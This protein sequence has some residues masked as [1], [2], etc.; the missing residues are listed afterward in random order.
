MPKAHLTHAFCVTAECEPG[1]KKTDWWCDRLTG[2]VLESRSSG[3]RTY[4]L[5]Y[6]DQGGRARQLKIGRF[7]DISHEAAVKAAKRLRSEVVLGGDP[8]AV[9]KEKRAVPTFSTLAAQA[10][11]FAKTYQ[12]RPE[13]FESILRRHVLDRW[14]KVRLDEITSRDVAKWLAEKSESGLAPATVEKVRVAL[15]RCLELGIR[16]ELPGAHNPL[17]GVPRRPFNNARNRFLSTEEAQ[18]LLRACERSSNHQLQHIVGLLLLTGARK[19]ELLHA[20]WKDVD[21][22]RGSWFIPDTKTKPRTVPLPQAAVEILKQLPRWDG[23]PYLLPNTETL[24]P[25][26]SIKR[27][28]M[29]SRDEAR[30][31]DL[32]IHDLRHSA[33][34]FWAAGGA[35]LI[36]IGA[37]LGHADHKST[38][39]YSHLANDTLLAA[40]EAGARRM[41]GSVP[42]S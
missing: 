18:R 36:T 6:T 32:R 12:K 21:L 40:V 35:S 2:F 11:N 27:A 8:L 7:G 30:L 15:N 22:E 19:S 33:A 13:N 16:W 31:G 25:F 1:K 38:M 39:R 29:T 41:S 17:K 9:K 10:V 34:S 4:Y 23:C 37:V 26:V 14:G 42:K 28:W 5:R 3:Q 24:K 20:E